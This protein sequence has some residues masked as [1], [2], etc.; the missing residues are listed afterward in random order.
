MKRTKEFIF[1]G[2]SARI[3]KSIPD[4]SKV[5]TATLRQLDALEAWAQS[6]GPERPSTGGKTSRSR[7]A[8]TAVGMSKKTL[9]NTLTDLRKLNT[10][11]GKQP[12][13]NAELYTQAQDSGALDKATR[14]RAV[15]QLDGEYPP[16][17]HK[18]RS[19]S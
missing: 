9:A 5:F 14:Y 6:C 16:P 11:Q 18:R 1:N 12:P 2:G 13:T 4:S 15:D 8:A 19:N 17:N 10:L 3:S 7:Q